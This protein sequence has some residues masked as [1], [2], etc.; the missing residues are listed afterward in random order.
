MCT[1]RASARPSICFSTS[2]PQVQH[3]ITG[4]QTEKEDSRNV[5]ARLVLAPPEATSETQFKQRISHGHHEPQPH[6]TWRLARATARRLNSQRAAERRP[7][8]RGGPTANKGGAS[9]VKIED[10]NRNPSKRRPHWPPSELAVKMEVPRKNDHTGP[11][12]NPRKSGAT[13]CW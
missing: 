6:P 7:H 3:K 10:G 2:R 1:H 11:P 4:D 12:R 13:S 5:D 9:R 8:A